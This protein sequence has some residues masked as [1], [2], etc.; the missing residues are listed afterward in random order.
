MEVDSN[1]FYAG[2]EHWISEQIGSSDI[3]TIYCRNR[4]DVKFLEQICDLIEFCSG[5]GDDMV[6]SFSCRPC[7]YL[8]L[9]R[10]LTDWISAKEDNIP[11]CGC[12]IIKVV[13]PINIGKGMKL[14]WRV[15]TKKEIMIEGL[16]KIS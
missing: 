4:V 3:I 13:C 14:K 7:D 2:V 1:M 12:Y 9:L 6:F 11:R 16:L 10:T 8:L 5:S 15:C